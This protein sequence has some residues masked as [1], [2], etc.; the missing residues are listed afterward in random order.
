MNAPIG[1][2][3]L[4][5]LALACAASLS[6]QANPSNADYAKVVLYGDVTIAQDSTASWGIWEQLEPPAAGVQAPTIALRTSGDLYRPLGQLD[7]VPPVNPPVV[8]EGL[9]ASGALCGFGTL[10]D[11]SAKQPSSA[12]PQALR[13]PLPG[14]LNAFVMLP[15]ALP[16]DSD[17]ASWLPARMRL[18]LQMLSGGTAG[19]TDISPLNLDGTTHYYDDVTG[20]VGEKM[21][22]T[23]RLGDTRRSY[24][25]N[26]TAD[27]FNGDLERYVIGNSDPSNIYQT[28]SGVWGVTT[29]AV[30]MDTL[31]KGQVTAT[32]F[33]RSTD[34]GKSSAGTPVMRVNF[35]NGSFT[36]SFNGGADGST[37]L[38]RTA[39]G[40]QV[41]GQVGFNV[42]AGVIRGSNFESTRLSA[43]DGTVSG[44]VVGAFFGPGAAV[45]AGAT[46]IIKTKVATEAAPGYTNARHVNTFLLVKD[47]G[48]SEVQR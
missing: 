7:P 4:S 21:R 13:D 20:E 2:I 29:T 26:G 3:R 17:S 37:Y 30:D 33:G 47:G 35:G 22:L 46:D 39:T 42:D 23:T 43:T 16:A 14:A 44:R 10:A 36:A 12:G 41:R 38:E 9:C 27:P 18:Q 19:L 6:A 15:E 1:I 24:G 34:D 11:R 28:F 45:A 31:S 32:Y 25:V 40:T 48:L 8:V 5:A